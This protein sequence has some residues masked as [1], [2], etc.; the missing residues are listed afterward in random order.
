MAVVALVAAGCN[1]EIKAPKVETSASQPSIHDD[2][3]YIDIQLPESLVKHVPVEP[4]PAGDVRDR[5]GCNNAG[6]DWADFYMLGLLMLRDPEEH[7]VLAGKRCWPRERPEKLADAG[8][9]CSGQADCIGNC[10]AEPQGDGKWSGPKCQAYAAWSVC[11]PL[12]EGGQYH[13]ITCPIP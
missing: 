7:A 6:G 13:W 3:T 9:A 4:D 8:K 12:Y 10:M 5:V 2:V 11:G 1:G